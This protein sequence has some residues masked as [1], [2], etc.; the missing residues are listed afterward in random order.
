VK[1]LRNYI[2]NG[3]QPFQRF[4]DHELYNDAKKELQDCLKDLVNAFNDLDEHVLDVQSLLPHIHVVIDLVKDL[5]ALMHAKKSSLKVIEFDDMERLAYEILTHADYDVPSF[6]QSQYTD[7]LVDEFQDTN[8]LQNQIITLISS[9]NNVFRVGDVKQSIYRFRGAK[10][11]LMRS[12]VNDPKF[13]CVLL[14]LIT[15]DRAN[16]LLTST[17][18]YLVH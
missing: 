12:M 3:F 1:C 15:L 10:P 4:R 14:Y 2:L 5:T 16:L 18:L 13:E 11:Q 9:G 17:I 8:D 7:I 6:Y